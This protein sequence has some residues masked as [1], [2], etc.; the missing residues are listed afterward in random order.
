MTLVLIQDV[1]VTIVAIAAAAVIGR[2]VIAFAQPSRAQT[3]CSGCASPHRP[4]AGQPR[5]APVEPVPVRVL[6]LRPPHRREPRR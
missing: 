5:R 2:R 1:S 4:C 3:G 6:S